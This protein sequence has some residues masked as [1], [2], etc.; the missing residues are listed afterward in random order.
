MFGERGVHDPVVQAG[1]AAA[2]TL[3]EGEVAAGFG[4]QSA[5]V[6]AAVLVHHEHRGGDGDGRQADVDHGR[7]AGPD[8]VRCGAG[9]LEEGVDEVGAG[10]EEGA[11]TAVPV[12]AQLSE[13]A[14]PRL[15]G[16]GLAGGDP[17]QLRPCPLGDHGSELQVPVVVGGGDVLVLQVGEAG[18][19]LLTAP[20]GPGDQ[21]VRDPR[22]LHHRPAPGGDGARLGREPE[23]LADLGGHDL[24]VEGGGGDG[25]LEEDLGVNR[26]PLPIQALSL[27]RQQEV[28]VEQ[29]HT[30]P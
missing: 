1:F 11:G 23:G 3:D 5:A 25:V 26:T 6:E 18:G 8:R 13:G 12:L 15:R 16:A 30:G 27:N 24:V 9:A 4:E 10:G 7:D 29:G 14:G 17:V 22:D 19:D 21:L 28:V 20:G 2:A